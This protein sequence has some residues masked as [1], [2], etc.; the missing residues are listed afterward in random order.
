MLKSLF[1][2]LVAFFLKKDC[3]ISLDLKQKFRSRARVV[4]KFNE[5]LVEASVFVEESEEMSIVDSLQGGR[6]KGSTGGLLYRR[7][8][9]F[10]TAARVFA[11]YKICQWRCNQMGTD[12]DEDVVNAIWNQ[13][14]ERNAK[15]LGAKFISLEGLWV[16][17]GQYLSSRADVMPEPYLRVLAKCQDSL[18]PKPFTIIKAQIESELKREIH[19]VFRSVDELPIAC[20]SIAQVHKAQLNNGQMVVIK[21]QHAEVAE[22][23]LQD[24]RNLET[25]GD[26]LKRFDPDFDFSPVIREWASEIPK[27]LDFRS[28]ASNMQRVES[29]LA[30][31]LPSRTDP[32]DPGMTNIVSDSPID[33]INIIIKSD[34]ELNSSMDGPVVEEP[35][36]LSIDVSLPTV[37]DELVTEKILVMSYIDGYKVDDRKLLDKYGVDRASVVSNI[38]RAFA[39]QIFVDG[40]YTADPHP[41]NLMVDTLTK[42]PVL[43]DFGLTKEVTP[44]ARYYFSIHVCMNIYI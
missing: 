15:F 34:D 19:S 2:F 7:S 35:A 14:H 3:C 31:R 22:R 27:E 36:D 23:L 17:L 10:Y 20:A 28:E 44:K 30:P 1:L 41:G 29:N 37:I 38:T 21:V 43:L 6:G 4:D 33:D 11:D 9:V 24:L 40:F 26:T 25:I 32:G 5:Q 13:T 18:P 16:K 12:A 42:K 8:Q 39:H